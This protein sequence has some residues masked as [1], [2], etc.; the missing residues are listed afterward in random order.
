MEEI[1]VRKA[2]ESDFAFFY[3]IK[4]DEDN[5][6]WSGHLSPPLFE[7]L[8]SFFSC[9]IR[10]ENVPNKRTIFIVE[11]K[12]GGKRVGYLYLDQI[13]TGSVEIS[14]GIMQ[15]FSGRGFGRKA[16]CELCKIAYAEGF[17]NI[18]AMVREDNLKSQRMFLHAGFE[19]TDSFKIQFI[20]NLNKEI[21]M[22]EFKHTR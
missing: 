5:I 2:E 8:Y 22:L 15:T 20:K 9:N 19:K 4:C 1:S 10:H 17:E 3:S 14:I 21:K 7:N 11:E 13:G 16:V 18:Y 12:K 6:Y